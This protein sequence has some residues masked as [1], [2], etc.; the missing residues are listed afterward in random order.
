MTSVQTVLIVG[1]GNSGLT[2]GALLA[3]GGVRV[4]IVERKAEVIDLGSGIT[5]QGPAK[6]VLQEV[7]VLDELLRH[8][9]EFTGLTLRS[10][11]GRALA[12]LPSPP[13]LGAYRPKL[14]ELLLAAATQAGA[15]IRLGTSVSSLAQDAA[16]V[17]VTFSD[18]STVRYDLVVGAD[19]VRSTTRRQIGI[20]AEPKPT[21]LGA[22]RAVTRRPADVTTSELC[23]DGPCYI[24]GCTPTGPD[25]I[26]AFLVESAQDRSA[27]S[28]EQTV[29]AMRELAQAYQGPWV[30][31]REDITDA[32]RINYTW[33]E[34][35]LVDG[36]W[37][38]GRIVL[39]G[40]AAHTCPPTIALGVAMALEDASVLAEMLLSREQLDQNLFDDFAARRMPRVRAVVEGSMQMV[41]WQLE[42]SADADVAGLQRRVYGAL[43]GPA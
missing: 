26:Y 22:F 32:A 13:T 10:V 39:I 42:G 31:I 9:Y 15:S 7:G 4:E 17:D 30:Q 23:Y 12:E 28:P 1:A 40:D 34:Y 18:S 27:D 43:A 35:L 19:G 36:P 25:S 5:L 8:G 20:S 21:G 37:N 24:A 2:L 16:G 38:R 11:D 6:R 14:T 29:A 3:R 41:T 33:F